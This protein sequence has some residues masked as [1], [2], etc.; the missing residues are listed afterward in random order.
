MASRKTIDAAQFSTRTGHDRLPYSSGMVMRVTSSARSAIHAHTVIASTYLV[1]NAEPVIAHAASLASDTSANVSANDSAMRTV[2]TIASLVSLLP[3]PVV[4]PV[5]SM[6]IL[7]HVR[8]SSARL[9]VFNQFSNYSI[10]Q[11]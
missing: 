2:A 9:D 1:P 7:Y 11:Y 3:E 8:P 10:I 4:L 5:V 6:P